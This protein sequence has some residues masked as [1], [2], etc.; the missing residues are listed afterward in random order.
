M[1]IAI[2]SGGLSHERD[3]SLASGSLIAK[4]LAE[5]GHKVVLLDVCRNIDAGEHPQDLFTCSPNSA[6]T[7]GESIPDLEALTA[8]GCREIGEGVM[9]VCSA[10]DVVFLALHGGMGENGKLQA[11]LDNFSIKYTGSGY[12]GSLLAMDKDLAKQTMQRAGVLTPAWIYFNTERDTADKVLETVGLPCVVKPA[13]SGSSVGVSIVEDREALDEA[14]GLGAKFEKYLIVERKIE[15]REFSVGILGDEVLPPIEIIPLEGFYDYKNKYQA[16]KTRE[17]CPAELTEAGNKALSESA[18]R[19]FSA[20]RLGGYARLDY[21]ID[22][23]GRAW[24]L[25]A[26]T[27]PGMTPTSLLPQEAAAVGIDYG[28]LCER[29]IELA[30]QK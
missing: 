17:I 25:E 7:V 8:E 29:I 1:N 2:L 14:L 16:G 11:T 18:K 30:L 6:A 13:S 3:V 23:K 15:G 12:I 5:R 22:E 28:R 10:A 21:I 24:C 26:N 20:L 27:L 4:A 19:A 9:Q